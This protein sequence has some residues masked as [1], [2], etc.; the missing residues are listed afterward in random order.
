VFAQLSAEIAE[1]TQLEVCVLLEIIVP[2]RV[3]YVY[4]YF[5]VVV[6]IVI[7]IMIIIII[8]IIIS[9]II[10]ALFY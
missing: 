1:R 5:I 9:S 2:F 3:D 7:I 4:V 10:I 6:I 8:I